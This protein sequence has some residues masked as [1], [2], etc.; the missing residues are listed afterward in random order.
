VPE[1][2]A[3][4]QPAGAALLHRRLPAPVGSKAFA[5]TLLWDLQQ[6]SQLREKNTHVLLSSGF[7]ILVIF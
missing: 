7:I 5:T 6:M 1:H 4:P 2:Q 3:L